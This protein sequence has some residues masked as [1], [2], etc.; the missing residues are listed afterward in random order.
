MEPAVKRLYPQFEG[1]LSSFHCRVIK[2]EL[3]LPD[4]G[5]AVLVSRVRHHIE[6]GRP[7]LKLPLPID[8][9]GERSADQ[10]GTLRVTLVRPDGVSV[11]FL[12]TKTGKKTN[13]KV[14]L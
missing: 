14:P 3:V 11:C 9:G 10:K 7:H 12:V 1:L 8:D 13:E 2:G 4:D 5:S 6:V